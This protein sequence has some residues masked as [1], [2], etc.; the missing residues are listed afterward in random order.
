MFGLSYIVS[1]LFTCVRTQK[2]RDSGNPRSLRCSGRKTNI[3]LRYDKTNWAPTHSLEYHIWWQQSLN[4]PIDCPNPS[5]NSWGLNSN[6]PTSTPNLLIVLMKVVPL[7]SSPSS[8][9][10]AFEAP[11]RQRKYRLKIAKPREQIKLLMKIL[12]RALWKDVM[13]P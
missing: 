12:Q 9:M 5:P 2:L 3:V 4:V 13:G 11:V 10:N 1:I 6:F 8:W 7:E